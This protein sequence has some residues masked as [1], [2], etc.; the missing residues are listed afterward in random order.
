MGYY[1]KVTNPQ[2]AWILE[3][4]AVPDLRSAKTALTRAATEKAR[5][6]PDSE[7]T[8]GA[9]TSADCFYAKAHTDLAQ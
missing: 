4:S 6:L 1:S 5:S 9:K 7:Q 8:T 3:A 2:H